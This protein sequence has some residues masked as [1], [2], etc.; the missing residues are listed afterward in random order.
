M[1]RLIFILLLIVVVMK[2]FQ[3]KVIIRLDTLFRK[4]FRK[5]NDKY[6]VFCWVR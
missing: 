5:N 1:F 3:N 6:G 2:M 4:G